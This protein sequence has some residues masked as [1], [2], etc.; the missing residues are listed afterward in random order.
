MAERTTGEQSK[1]DLLARF[2]L[3]AAGFSTVASVALHVFGVMPL[4]TGVR[5]FVMPFAAAGLGAAWCRPAI[6]R[7][8]LWGWLCG[9]IAVFAY[10]LSRLPFIAAGWHDFVPRLGEW[11]LDGSGARADIPVGYGYRYLGNGGGLGTAFVMLTGHVARVK[12]TIAAGV[13]FGLFVFGV[14]CVVLFSAPHADRLMF[15]VTLVSLTGSLT[16]HVVYGAVLGACVTA[17]PEGAR[18]R[19]AAQLLDA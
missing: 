3:A 16:G 15:P 11:L 4:H 17:S 2:V 14:L 19:A 12:P 10:D 5:W 1:A 13:L 6:G 18:Q 9:L 8:A 7:L